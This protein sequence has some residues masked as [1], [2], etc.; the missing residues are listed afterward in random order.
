M[1]EAGRDFWFV[2]Y[3]VERQWSRF[4]EAVGRFVTRSRRVKLEARRN[5]VRMGSVGRGEK[6]S[7]VVLQADGKGRR[8]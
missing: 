6:T 3:A 5:A 7:V 1:D 8:Q 2:G 4:A